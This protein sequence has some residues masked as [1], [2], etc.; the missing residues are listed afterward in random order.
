VANPETGRPIRSDVWGGTENQVYRDF[1][2]YDPAWIDIYPGPTYTEPLG[3]KAGTHLGIDVAMDRG[4]KLYAAS[5]GKVQVGGNQLWPYFRPKPVY[6]ETSDDPNTREDESGYIEIYGHMWDNFVSVGQQVKPGDFL[7]HSGEETYAGTMNPDGTGAH[8]HFELRKPIGQGQYRAVDPYNWLTGAKFKTTQS[9][10]TSTSTEPTTEN[11]TSIS[12]I[13]SLVN[14]FLKRGLFA[15]LGI[16]FVAIG[17][18]VL[19]G[20]YTPVG[21]IFNKLR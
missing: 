15:V 8:L 9:D 13:S 18:F 7:G 20:G 12:G 5:Y 21:R 6:V 17:L 3:Y 16:A 2:W 14:E 11:E 1:G 4:T 10:D 19:I